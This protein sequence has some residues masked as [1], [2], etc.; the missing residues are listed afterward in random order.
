MEA[1]SIAAPRGDRW[2]GVATISRGKNRA[3][4]DVRQAGKTGRKVGRKERST[5]M[6]APYVHT[7]PSRQAT[8]RQPLGGKKK[9]LNNVAPPLP[10]ANRV[11]RQLL[12]GA[13]PPQDAST[14][15]AAHNPATAS[16]GRFM[17]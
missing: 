12:D 16:A 13:T 17:A 11:Q 3:S 14:H 5:G 9:K 4:A 2:P 6:T 10:S 8:E 7:G 1:A 15:P